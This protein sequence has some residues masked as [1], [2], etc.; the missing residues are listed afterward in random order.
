M[1]A[2]LL[3]DVSTPVWHEDAGGMVPTSATLSVV[4][5]DGTAL[6]S[7]TVTLPSV[8][9]TVQASTTAAAIILDSATGFAV[10][11]AYQVTSDGVSYVFRVA[12]IDGATIYPVAALPQVP[13]TSST[14]KALRMTATV[15]APGEANIGEGYAL[16]WEYSD[17]T[18]TRQHA[19]ETSVVRWLWQ[20]PIEAWE[21]REYVAQAF[22]S[23]SREFQFYA[24]TAARANGWIRSRIE[25]T[26]K[27]PAL[28]GSSAAFRECGRLAVQLYLAERGLIPRGM[29]PQ[30]YYRDLSFRANEEL[31]TQV[32]GLRQY[33]NDDSGT[34]SDDDLRARGYTASVRR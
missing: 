10:G 21:V 18:T 27:R 4:K 6:A 29:D 3:Y 34:L 28:Y 16:R 13:D 15:A 22:P 1:S 8:T 5:P 30:T 31:R 9:A 2:D 25:A 17:G 20:T 26:G 12:R 23:A 24:D 11:Q 7:P 19:A 14:V 33:D 32:A